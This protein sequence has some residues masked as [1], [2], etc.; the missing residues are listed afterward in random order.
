MPEMLE[1]IPPISLADPGPP[2]RPDVY[3]PPPQNLPTEDGIPLESNWHRLEI[4]LLIEII[5]W[6][7]R[8]RSDYFAGGNMFVYFS[9]DETLLRDVR[10]PD[11]FLVNG[12]PQGDRPSWFVWKEQG[13]YPDLI[14]ELSSPTTRKI[15]FT[16]KFKIY[17]QTFRTP[18][19][20]IYDPNTGELFAWRNRGLG[21]QAIAPN[22]R[23]HVFLEQAGLWLGKWTGMKHPYEMTWLRFFDGDGRLV[24]TAAEAEKTRA[25]AEKS[26]ADVEKSRADAADALAAAEKVRADALA[27]ELAELK[28]KLE[29]IR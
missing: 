21:Y 24:P 29:E 28:A 17:E 22:E 3:I 20:V 10:G 27:V 19:Y 12:V 2:P 25:D 15:D 5:D 6:H 23:G 7:R 26:R 1:T 13:R 9:D 11:F 14:I 8:E 4:N 16:T 18:E